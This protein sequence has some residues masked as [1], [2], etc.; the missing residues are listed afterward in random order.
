MFYEKARKEDPP[1]VQEEQD[2]ETVKQETHVDATAEVENP[3]LMKLK[4]PSSLFLLPYQ[5]VKDNKML[6]KE[7]QP[8]LKKT[9]MKRRLKFLLNLMKNQMDPL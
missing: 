2:T 9:E 3:L 1:N 8:N 6:E 5:P 7:V 4:Q